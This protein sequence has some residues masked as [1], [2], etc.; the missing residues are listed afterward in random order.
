[1]ARTKNKLSST[2]PLNDHACHMILILTF[3]DMYGVH[4][5]G[6]CVCIDV[7]VCV[8]VYLNRHSVFGSFSKRAD[9]TNPMRDVF[10][11]IRH[12]FN[13]VTQIGARTHKRDRE[14]TRAHT[15]VPCCSVV[16]GSLLKIF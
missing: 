13:L 12:W 7:C 1:L 15:P 8:C 14:H 2:F 4:A 11:L 16:L 6:M 5:R 3:S 9:V 10:D